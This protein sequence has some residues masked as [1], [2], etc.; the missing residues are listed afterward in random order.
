MNKSTTLKLTEDQLMRLLDGML[1]VQ[2]PLDPI[3]PGCIKFVSNDHKAHRSLINRLKRALRRVSAD[4][5]A[6]TL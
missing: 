4:A 3:E 1:S 2:E 6:L 5:P